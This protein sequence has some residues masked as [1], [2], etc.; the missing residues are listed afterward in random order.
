MLVTW[1]LCP[2][3]Q[4]SREQTQTSAFAQQNADIFRDR[5]FTDAG[6]DAYQ[7]CITQMGVFASVGGAQDG[8]EGGHGLGLTS[9]SSAVPATCYNPCDDRTR[10]RARGPA[11]MD[12]HLRVLMVDAATSYHRID[13][14]PVGKPF[15]GPVDLGLHLA[16]RHNSLNLG[17]GL[18]A[19]SIFPGSNRLIVTGFSPCWGGFY[20]STMGGAALVFD[21]LGVNLLSSVGRAAMPSILY[22]NREGGEHVE[23]EIVP[24][25]V[26][27]VWEQEPG[28]FDVVADSAHNADIGVAILDAIVQR[29]GI[30]DLR[31]GARK[32]ARRLARDKGREVLDPF[33]YTAFARK[34]WMVPNQYWT[35]GALSPMAVMGKYY[36]YYGNDF[37]PPREL[38]RMNADLMKKELALD[39]LGFCRFHRGWAEEMIPTIIESLY[40]LKDRLQ[41]QIAATASRINSRNA[42][43]CWESERSIDYVYT[44]LKRKQTVD[45]V[46]RPELE[47]WIKQFETNKQEAALAFW[48]EVHKGVTESLREF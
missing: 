30:V 2:F 7:E 39:N 36:M 47:S 10:S 37:L 33:V 8:S 31:E 24:L 13:R 40:G 16:G 18:L 21:N 22:L 32:F 6:P 35:P 38:G 23:V 41:E 48:Y 29:R 42:S 34:G 15:F 5:L 46:Q 3:F 12:M 14:Y 1:R 27:Q 28:G 11:N 19:G 17:A 25:D 20:V 44:F 45:G 4:A 26:R 9:P 43:A